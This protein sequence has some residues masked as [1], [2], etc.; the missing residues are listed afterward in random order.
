MSRQQLLIGGAWTD[1]VI[2][3]FEEVKSPFDKSVVG[4][5]G[6]A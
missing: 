4:E 1:T 5:V 6:V 2:K 3:N